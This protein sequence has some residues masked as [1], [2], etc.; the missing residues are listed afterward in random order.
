MNERYELIV[1]YR[2]AGRNFLQAAIPL[3][4]E[5]KGQAKIDLYQPVADEVMGGLFARVFR[6]FQT[7]LLDYHLWAVDLGPV[8][9]RMMLESIFYMR[10]LANQNQPELYLEFQRFGIGQEKLYKLQL[11]KLLDEG[12]LE[13]TPDLR[14][15]IESESDEEISDELVSV[16]LK[17][18]MDI[19]KLANDAGMADEYV[20]HY[21]PNSVHIHGHWPVLRQFYLETCREPLHRFHLQPSFC[22]PALD[23]SMVARA[24]LLMGDA[25][26]IW[27]DRY[28]LEDVLE[29]LIGAY[30]AEVTQR[31]P[32]SAD[33]ADSV[34]HKS[35]APEE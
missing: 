24:A 31:T 14:R 3:L 6:F 12:K 29:A 20:L 16:Q 1:K 21:Q 11:S 26:D 19:R 7:F 25:Y 15:F 22:L 30:A 23:S 13:D 9:L 34:P 35:D 8:V 17:N 33:S 10:F 28:G 5:Q 27:R 2:Q 32:E 4:E 18:F